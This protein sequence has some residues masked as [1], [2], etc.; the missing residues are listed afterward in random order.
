MLKKAISLIILVMYLHGMSGYTMSFHTCMVTGFENVYTGYGLED[1]CGEE[2]KDCNETS[3]HFEPADCCDLEQTIVSVDDDR[4]LSNQKISL[5]VP[6]VIY[7][8]FP[9]YLSSNSSLTH[10]FYYSDYFV[11]PPGLIDICVFRI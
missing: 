8:L 3:T 7:T 10:S 2:E 4:D 9:S 11:R 6:F 5:T 1:P